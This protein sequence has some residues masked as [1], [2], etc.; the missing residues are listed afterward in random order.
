M[1][2]QRFVSDMQTRLREFEDKL[3]RLAEGPAPRSESARLERLK[4]YYYLK[5]CHAELGE[6]LREEQYTPDE[7]WREFKNSL[8]LVYEDMARQLA[9][10]MA[11]AER[12][13][14]KPDDKPDQEG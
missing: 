5:A 8:E 3:A 4:T 10:Q 14:D 9:G 1:V 2:R 7:S 12:P 13:D 6:R 11:G